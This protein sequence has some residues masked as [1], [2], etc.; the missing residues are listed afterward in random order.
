M[1]K[2]EKMNDKKIALV[3]GANK[4]MG[5]ETVKQ[6]A[7]KGMHVILTSRDKAK[8]K[9]AVQ[10][11]KE[12]KLDVEFF[13]LD[14]SN[15]KSIQKVKNFVEKKFGRLDILINNAGI[16]PDSGKNSFHH[17]LDGKIKDIQKALNTNTFGP[18][19][20][21]Q[22]FI[23]L[24]QKNNFGRIVNVSSSMGSLNKMERNF[25]AYRMSKT[26]LNVVTR[27]LADETKECNIK[28]NSVCPGWVRTDMGS[29]DADKSVEEGVETTIWLA[30]LPDKGPTG[31]FFQ[32]KKRIEW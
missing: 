28:I 9:E 31:G 2:T 23:P 21:C 3:T 5:F 22:S 15:S 12:Q 27:I 10:K 30:T 24:M 25:P 14:V 7:Q 17:G 19:Q 6:L 11:L 20:L 18:L 26:A 29:P 1:G 32:D 16:F 8:G 4:G 13:Q